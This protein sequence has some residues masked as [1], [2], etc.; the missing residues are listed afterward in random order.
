MTKLKIVA[1]F[2]GLVML[3]IIPATVSAQRVPPPRIRGYRHHGRRCGAGRDHGHR[4]GRWP[5]SS[6][7]NGCRWHRRL[8]APGGPGRH[9]LH[10]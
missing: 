9:V 2:L 7:D 4:I 1:L 6:V 5:K 10:R 8:H 3:F